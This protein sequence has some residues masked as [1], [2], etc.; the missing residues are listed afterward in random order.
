MKLPV[1]RSRCRQSQVPE[2]VD[3]DTQLESILDCVWRAEKM[4][5]LED[6]ISMELRDELPART[7]TSRRDPKDEM[8]LS[9]NM[10]PYR[11]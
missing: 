1:L 11:C 4:W 5:R 6:R 9:S 3:I 7:G 2:T 8:S 10:T